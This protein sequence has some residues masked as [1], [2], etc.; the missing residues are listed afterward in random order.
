MPSHLPSLMGVSP[1]TAK[2]TVRRLL[3]KTGARTTADVLR[4]LLLLG[5][6]HDA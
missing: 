4:L 2:T 1:N 6:N 3:K 5:V